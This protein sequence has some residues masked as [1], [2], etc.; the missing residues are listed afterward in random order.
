MKKLSMFLFAAFLFFFSTREIKANSPAHLQGYFYSNLTSYGTWISL[1]FGVYAWRPTIITRSWAPYTIGRW[2]WT[3]YGWYWE[4]YEPFGFIVYHYG[5][6]YY[7][8][9]YG[10]IWIPDYEWAPAWVEW[11]YDD[12]YIGWAPLPP[13]AVFRISV[14][15]IYTHSYVIPVKH[16]HF[17]SFR[18]FGNPYLYNYYVPERTKYRIHSNT[19]YRNEYR[20]SDG[21]IRNEGVDFDFVRQRAGDNIRKSDLI[22]TD[23]PRN[24][25]NNRQ[26]DRDQITTFIA[27]KVRIVSDR[28]SLRD[29]KVTKNERR[30]SLEL[31]RIEL[32]ETRSREERVR[33]DENEIFTTRESKRKIL[34]ERD[35]ERRDSERRNNEKRDNDQVREFQRNTNTQNQRRIGSR[36]N[37]I[38]R[39]HERIQFDNN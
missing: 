27:D 30:T 7:E 10:W 29:I 5:R 28:E 18:H 33:N 4:S 17:V 34:Q 6:W 24:I 8:E 32:S 23:D 19:K 21:R 37:E 36:E 38:N 1:D 16:W 11:R 2:I 20:Y 35:D 31:S 12:S 22:I 9:Y 39:E 13:Y 25:Q 15:I 26:R 3:D 14:G